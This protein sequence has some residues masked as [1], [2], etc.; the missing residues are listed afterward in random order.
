[1]FH[2]TINKN[3]QRKPLR[4]PVKD[5]IPQIR[6]AQA[7]DL[8]AFNLLVRNFQDMAVGYAYSLLG[9]FHLAQDAAQE[10]FLGAFTD[11]PDLRQP[12]GFAAWLRQLVFSRCRQFTRKKH[13]PTVSLENPANPP[14]HTADPAPDPARLATDNDM[15]LRI[16]AYIQELPDA[17]RDA[18]SL[19]YISSYSQKEI[20][21]FLDISVDSV[22]NRLRTARAKLKEKMLDMVKDTL[23]QN[24]PSRDGNFAEE[25]DRSVLE[26]QMRLACTTGDLQQ[27][28]ALLQRDP[29][30]IDQGYAQ[31]SPLHLAA[32]EGHAEIVELL[33]KKG[34]K[35]KDLQPYKSVQASTLEIVDIRGH[36]S[37]AKRLK[38]LLQEGH[39]I[40]PAG[41][42]FCTA[43]REGQ[44]DAVKQMLNKNPGV[45]SQRDGRGN[46]GLHWAVQR[47]NNFSTINQL[48]DLGADLEAIND[49]GFKP[50]HLSIW[51]GGYWARQPDGLDAVTGYLLARGSDY[52]ITLAAALGDKDTVRQRLEKDV[53]LAN[54]ADTCNR[55]PLSAAAQFGHSLIVELLLQHGADPNAKEHNC[56]GGYGLWT[57]A[58]NGHRD[59]ARLLLEYG[60]DPE[61]WLDSCGPPMEAAMRAG[62]RDLAELVCLYGGAPDIKGYIYSQDVLAVTGILK[63]DP[64][65]AHQIVLSGARGFDEDTGLLILDLCFKQGATTKDISHWD[66]RGLGAMPRLLQKVMENGADPNKATENGE[67][68]LHSL[69][70]LGK[71]NAIGVLIEA[72]SD[73][74]ARDHDYRATPLAWAAMHGR[75]DTVEYLLERGAQPDLPD[76]KSWT[77]PLFWAERR[78]HEEIAELL[79][80]QAAV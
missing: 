30:L 56:K 80:Q 16:H 9:D 51:N 12:A 8:D 66:L 48:L 34:P 21:A 1:L 58:Q 41:E 39:S 54:A 37:I 38:A 79:R 69:A 27:A 13:H 67:T 75:K 53:T 63:A 42:A 46:T 40:V 24:A 50:I 33:L 32:R 62:H 23:H 35:P 6:R 3:H 17:E 19:F 76:D 64:E 68:I 70:G 78:G 2:Y 26:H 29:T 10:A 55:R 36:H 47:P 7:G 71:K 73:L 49:E 72:G 45:V 43:V 77:K 25:V 4:K 65:Q 60:A 52:T 61:G 44:A 11:L 57:A 5:L 22:K 74:N 20:G 15:R 14:I 59:I 31:A 18:I 28:K